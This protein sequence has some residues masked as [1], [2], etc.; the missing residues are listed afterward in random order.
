MKL[1]G[2]RAPPHPDQ[3]PKKGP[4]PSISSHVRSMGSSYFRL[5]PCSPSPEVMEAYEGE[6]SFV[7]VFIPSS[8]PL[9][10]DAVSSVRSRMTAR[11]VGVLRYLCLHR[12]IGVLVRGS[13]LHPSD[14]HC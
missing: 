13:D 14:L 10:A 6:S 11:R 2:R 9:H 8:T 5:L 1:S 12:P 3:L 7:S 4:A